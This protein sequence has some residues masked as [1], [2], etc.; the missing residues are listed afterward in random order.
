M[1]RPDYAALYFEAIR[2]LSAITAYASP[3]VGLLKEQ[4]PLMAA[5]LAEKA[6]EGNR[7]LDKIQKMEMPA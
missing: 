1:S 2:A 3:C 6:A 7:V 5:R 4:Y